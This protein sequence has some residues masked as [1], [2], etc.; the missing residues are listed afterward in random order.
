MP[1]LSIIKKYNNAS[2]L[3]GIVI[4]DKIKFESKED[5]LKWLKAMTV[6]ETDFEIIDYEWALIDL[7][8]GPAV[9]ENPVNGKIGDL[10]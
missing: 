3:N 6:I 7:G 4:G 2:P 10:K 8:A 1:T 9:L 5:G